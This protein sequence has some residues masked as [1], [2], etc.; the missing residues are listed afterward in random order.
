MLACLPINMVPEFAC[1]ATCPAN[2]TVWKKQMNRY[3]TRFCH[4]F[5]C[6]CWFVWCLLGWSSV[7]GNQEVLSNSENQGLSMLRYSDCLGRVLMWNFVAVPNSGVRCWMI[8]SKTSHP[9]SLWHSSEV[10]CIPPETF[11]ASD[12]KSSHDRPEMT[13]TL[14]IYVFTSPVKSMDRASVWKL[15]IKTPKS[16]PR[17]CWHVHEASKWSSREVWFQNVNFTAGVP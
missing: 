11:P 2:R 1:R 12:V 15:W 10:H 5:C 4:F 3:K 6:L 17:K 8:Y 13:A 7:T 9:N 14:N 16:H